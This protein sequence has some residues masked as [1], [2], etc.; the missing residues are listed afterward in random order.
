MWG[1][2]Y[3][4]MR[5]PFCDKGMISYMYKPRLTVRRA[6]RSA[7]AKGMSWKKSQSVYIFQTEKCPECGKPIE[8]I[9]KKLREDGI[10]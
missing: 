5:C 4:Q 3:E 8:E 6:V 10:I 1:L 2:E 7:A 9:E